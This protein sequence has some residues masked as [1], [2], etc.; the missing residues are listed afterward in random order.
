MQLDT[1]AKIVWTIFLASMLSSCQLFQK[2]EP[3]WQVN[4]K[5]YDEADAA[6]TSVSVS[7][8]DQ[9]AWLLDGQGR[10]LLKTNISTGVTGHETPTGELKVLEMLEEKKSNRY[11]KYVDKKKGE[12]V[13]AKSWLHQ[14]PPPAGTEYEGVDMP[15]WMR[16][17]W[18]GVGMHVGE[19][20]RHTR[21]SFGCVRVFHE[22]Q[23]WIYQKVQVGTS[24]EI[25]QDSMVVEMAGKEQFGFFERW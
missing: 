1:M 5:L 25:Y 16:L 24:V 14:G 2:G 17:T 11:G 18:W 10:V 3:S 4:Q 13:V 19:F 8:H 9:R 12:V 7:L 20:A 15:Y 22:A 21:C 6:E 23:P